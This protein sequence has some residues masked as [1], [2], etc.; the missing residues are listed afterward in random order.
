MTSRVS[1][2]VSRLSKGLIAYLNVSHELDANLSSLFDRSNLFMRLDV[3]ES[4]SKL[5][6]ARLDRIERYLSSSS[7]SSHLRSELD[8]LETTSSTL[9]D[10]NVST[11][12]VWLSF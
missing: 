4:G 12:T 6:E 2:V 7:R 8:I 11:D 1:K 10:F 5:F 3:F 9:R